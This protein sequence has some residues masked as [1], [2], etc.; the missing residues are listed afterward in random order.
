MCE[1]NGQWLF[2][3]IQKAFFLEGKDDHES[4]PKAHCRNGFLWA[5]NDHF[6][7]EKINKHPL[8]LVFFLKKHLLAFCQMIRNHYI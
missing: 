3:F 4:P 7:T 1:P 2:F 5:Q 6:I 8:I